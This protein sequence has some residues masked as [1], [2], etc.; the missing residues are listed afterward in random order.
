[1][2]KFLILYRASTE[3]FEKMMRQATPETREAGMKEWQEWMS[4][5][6]DSFADEGGPVG[7]PK[8]VTKAGASDARNDIG[9][10]SIIEADSIDEAAEMVAD[11]PHLKGMGESASIE[12]MEILE[13]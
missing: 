8:K 4:K 2:K 9:G 10:Y 3:D 12:V 11:S 5:H 7:K 13:M 1:M 6:G